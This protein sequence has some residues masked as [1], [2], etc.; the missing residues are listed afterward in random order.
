MLRLTG[1][2]KP[3]KYKV[4][5]SKFLI[6]MIKIIITIDLH[7]IIPY[8]KSS[9]KCITNIIYAHLSSDCYITLTRTSGSKHIY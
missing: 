3:V 4:P 1:S 6:K 7:V 5:R 8:S 9:F 2:D